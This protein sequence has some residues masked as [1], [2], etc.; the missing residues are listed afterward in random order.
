MID[1]ATPSGIRLGVFKRINQIWIKG[2]NLPKVSLIFT[3][4]LV[5]KN[6]WFFKKTS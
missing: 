5:L 4:K 3:K 1:I 2:I 6:V